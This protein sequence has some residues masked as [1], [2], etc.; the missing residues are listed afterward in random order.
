M[1]KKITKQYV[2]VKQIIKHAFITASKVK[3]LSVL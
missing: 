2:K 3:S 1:I